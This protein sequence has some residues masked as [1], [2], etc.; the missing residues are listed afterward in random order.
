MRQRGGSAQQHQGAAA[1]IHFGEPRGNKRGDFLLRH[2]FLQRCKDFAVNQAGGFAG[3]AHKLEFLRRFARAARDDDGISGQECKG[4]RGGAKM[5]EKGE[6]KSLFDADAAGA[7]LVGGERGNDEMRGAFV[8]LPK[9]KVEREAQG[10]AHAG[11]FEG[12]ADENGLA[13]TRNDE[14]EETFAE[15]PTH[16]REVVER[17]TGADDEAVKGGRYFGHAILHVKEAIA[18]VIGCEGVNAIAKRFEVGE[19]GRQLR[20]FSLSVSG[21][22]GRE[23]GGR[24]GSGGMEKT[25]TGDGGHQRKG[26]CGTR[27]RVKE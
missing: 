9:M 7:D 25:A 13:G 3:E 26:W 2:S 22:R 12:G 18:E 10:F 16:A 4:G 1:E 6:E 27:R 8:F 11:L 20:R 15:A 19:T 17:G 23:S 24:N 21:L 5:I 14:G